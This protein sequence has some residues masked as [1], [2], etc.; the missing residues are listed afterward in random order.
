MDERRSRRFSQSSLFEIVAA[1]DADRFVLSLI[2]FV[3][4]TFVAGPHFGM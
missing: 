1:S 4:F 2:A 3:L